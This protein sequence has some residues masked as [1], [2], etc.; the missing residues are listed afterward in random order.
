MRDR[1]VDVGRGLLVVMMIYGHVLQFFGD[2]Q[3]FPACASVVEIIN[4]T[5]FPAFV[6]YFGMT[7]AMAYLT[8]PYARA[9]PGMIRMGLRTYAAFVFSGVGFRVLRENKPL[10]AG[11]V[12]RVMT[13]MDVP[14]WSEFLMAFALYALLLAV[15]FKGFVFLSARP[16]YALAVGA[17][18]VAACAVP[19]DQTPIW[20]APFIG[21]TQFSYFPV[22]QYMPYFLTGMVFAKAEKP[23]RGR[24]LLLAAAASGAG[25]VY[26]C[27]RGNL[28]SRFPPEWAWIALSGLTTAVVVMAAKGLSALEKTSIRPLAEAICGVLAHF[29]SASLYMLLGSNLV[30]F[31]MS[32]KGMTPVLARTGM[33]PWTQPIQSPVGA[34]CW[35]ALLLLVL[36]F[37]AR[38]AG[39]GKA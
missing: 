12:R 4:L 31:T 18:C 32:G 37:V 7:A 13:L 17:V 35:T 9:L 16:R 33:L 34:A 3:L 28:P 14:G 6:F 26:V 24:L 2:A 30:L 20:L 38:L 21:G 5:V 36:W 8:K 19:Y 22:V 23:V 29:G 10:A 39:R 1:S 25:M 11:T 27:V 15:L